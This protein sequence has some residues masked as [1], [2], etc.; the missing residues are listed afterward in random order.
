MI[1]MLTQVIFRLPW[2][3]LANLSNISK[4]NWGD[5]QANYQSDIQVTLVQ[6]AFTVLPLALRN[7]PVYG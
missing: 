6:T 5:I 3:I 7:N 2:V 1:F 4:A